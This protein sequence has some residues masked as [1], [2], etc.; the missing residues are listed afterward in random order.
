VLVTYI[1]DHLPRHVHVYRDSRLAVKWDLDH[2]EAM[3]RQISRSI[4]RQIAV[5]TALAGRPYRDRSCLP[6]SP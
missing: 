1:G 3:E 4:L 5:G 2:D 6:C